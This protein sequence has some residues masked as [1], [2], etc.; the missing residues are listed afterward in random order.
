[1]KKILLVLILS[2]V[3]YTVSW[4]Q[5]CP[6]VSNPYGSGT[7]PTTTGVQVDIS[8]SCN[9]GGEYATILSCVAGQ[10]YRLSATDPTPASAS[11]TYV[12]V[13]DPS[14]NYVA[15]GGDLITGVTVDFTA[16][17]SGDYTVMITTSAP[18][19][20]GTDA[21]CRIVYVECMSCITCWSDNIAG[22]VS[23]DC[24]N[25]YVVLT[26]TTIAAGTYTASID[27]TGFSTTVTGPGTYNLGSGLTPDQLYN[28]TITD[29]VNTACDAGATAFPDC[30][31]LCAGATDNV[32]DGG[33][34]AASGTVWTESVFVNAGGTAPIV[35]TTLPLTGL[36][37][38]WLGGWGGSTTSVSQ[39]VTIPSG[40]TATFYF[41]MLLGVCDSAN[42]N[43]TV[44]V[45]GNAEYTVDGSSANCG[46]DW[47]QYSVDLSAYADGASHTLMIEAIEV[48][49]NA[50]QTNFFVDNVVL[51]HCPGGGV[52][53]TDY[54]LVGTESATNDYETD[55]QIL[56]IQTIT[57][58]ATV[59]YDAGTYIDLLSG[60]WAQSGCNFD[61]FIDGCNG[62]GGI[63]SPKPG[64]DIVADSPATMK[65]GEHTP[66][67]SYF[68]Y[69]A[70]DNTNTIKR[71]PKVKGRKT[72]AKVETTTATLQNTV[73]GVSP[74]PTNG[75]TTINFTLA[76]DDFANVSVYDIQ[77]RLVK[78]IFNG[79][80][81][82][83]EMMQV[84][85]TTNDM[86]DGVYMVR[87]TT[88]QKTENIRLVVS[89]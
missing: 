48:G 61:A 17:V 49:T 31:L 45:D 77:G 24:D 6:L 52:C 63:L 10:T 66:A 13:Y 21:T 34:E 47:I 36:Q 67:I 54:T 76:N 74:N 56:S 75:N 72:T 78:N 65:S 1:M 4:G 27:G 3:S 87:L 29:G 53:P 51:E 46:G 12:T 14:S 80:A 58:T 23:Y 18:T 22:D 37:S 20:C 33:F 55:G 26:L 16:S 30:T 70:T 11:P 68:G 84:K 43:I 5:G 25:N 41:W 2:L 85:L 71:L 42:D 39:T 44:Y 62:S 8:D 89:K 50:T 73:F 59:D 79:N 60:F 81:N 28:I 82:A 86:T 19:A 7:A 32:A 57:P 88:S 35:D 83:N 40:G 64:N 38:A 15:Y 9:Y 69:A